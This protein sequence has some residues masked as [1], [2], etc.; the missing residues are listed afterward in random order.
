MTARGPDLPQPTFARELEQLSTSAVALW[1]AAALPSG[2][3]LLWACEPEIAHVLTQDRGREIVLLEPR[4]DQAEVAMRHGAGGLRVLHV[5][6]GASGPDV[7]DLGMWDFS[8]A[9]VRD[10][11]GSFDEVLSPVLDLLLPGGAV[12]VVTEPRHSAAVVDALARRGRYSS[13]VEVDVAACAHISPGGPAPAQVRIVGDANHRD[14]HHLIVM[15]R[16]DLVDLPNVLLVGAEQGLP[17]WSSGLDQMSETLIELD[18]LVD[19]KHAARVAGLEA[20]LAAADARLHEA[21]RALDDRTA[22]LEAVHRSTSWR[23][24][25]PLRLAKDLMDRQ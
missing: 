23:I 24:T 3:T 17:A 11:L 8:A 2:P 14:A 6:W 18:R 12:A 1:L 22:A 9:V 21:Q 25:R 4:E 15:S 10:G 20:A 19:A 5:P 16:D 7:S 13:A